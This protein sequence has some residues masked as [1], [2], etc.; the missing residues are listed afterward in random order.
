MRSANILGFRLLFLTLAVLMPA[1]LLAADNFRPT[2]SW[3]ADRR[4]TPGASVPAI[5]FTVGDVETPAGS[6]TL[7][8]ESSN[9]T[10]LPVD[11]IAFGGSGANRT[12]TLTPVA[13]ELGAATVTLV[14]SDGAKSTAESFTLTVASTV[15]GNTVPVIQG[16]PSAVIPTGQ[17]YG[18]ALVIKDQEKSESSLTLSRKSSNPTLVPDSKITFGGQN[19]GRS[20][21]VTPVAG[22]TGRATITLSV[23]DATYTA[24]TSFVL[25]VVASNTGPT[26]VAPENQIIVLGAAAPTASF[27]VGD[28][29]TDAA[30][31]QVSAT[32]SNTTLL[33]N[34][35]IALGGSGSSRTATLTPNSGATGAAT[36]TLSV[37]DGELTTRTPFLLV[38]H[39][40]DSPGEQFQRPRG[41]YILDSGGGKSYTTTFGKTIELRDANHRNLPFIDG[42]T[43]RMR[44]IDVESATTPG[45]YDFH[46]IQHALDKL[47][48]G[49]KLSLMFLGGETPAYIAAKAGVTTWVDDDGNTQP[50]P[51][52]PYLRERRQAL[53]QAL[54]AAQ[55]DGVALPQ[56]PRLAILNPFL[57][58]GHTGIRDPNGTQLRHLP[59]YTR[60]K[61]LA[62]VQDELRTLTELF[63]NKFVQIGFWKFSDGENSAYGGK[64]AWEYLRQQLLAEFDGS[65]RPRIGFFMEN[66]AAKRTGPAIDPYSATPVTS[67][68]TPM[69][70]SQSSAWNS[71]QMLGSWTRP[72]NDGHVNNTLNGTP[73]DAMEYAFNTYRAEYHEVY[74]GD[75]DNKAMQPGLIAWHQ[76]FLTGV[77]TRDRSEVRAT[78]WTGFH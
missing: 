70:L 27:T 20:V 11:R 29:Q 60:A 33:P 19:W 48:A 64:E 37:T 40:P 10:L 49:Q 55:F 24:S 13:G 58:G 75:I 22:Q 6:L 39:D 47:A 12:V 53:L 43:L 74:I 62:T 36:I 18:H 68:A 30:D 17:A 69:H 56:H 71:F 51:W 76:F 31:L 38:V 34:A 9:L 8:A 66:L 42:F 26:L 67:Y 61:M 65:T 35:S 73:A 3:I 23:S 50:V 78:R 45:A 77:T 21:T 46:I 54:A 32:S 14:V 2:I 16:V 63:P 28:A 15:V 44:W 52:D 57:P 41:I 1:P 72:F 4:V 59:G 5:A 7:S 25:D